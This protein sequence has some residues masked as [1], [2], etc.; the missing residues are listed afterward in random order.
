[1]YEYNWLEDVGTVVI[2]KRDLTLTYD[3]WADYIFVDNSNAF[4]YRV[5]GLD[6]REPC[7]KITKEEAEAFMEANAK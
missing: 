4:T 3:K 5:N 1:M 2:N 6:N 7:R